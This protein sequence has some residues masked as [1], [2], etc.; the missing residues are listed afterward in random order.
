MVVV[1]SFAVDEPLAE[2]LEAARR[3]PEL[4]FF[5]TGNPELARRGLLA[6]K[7]TNVEFTGFVSEEKYA[8]LLRAADVVV[9]LTTHLRLG[10]ASRNLLSR[11]SP[12][13]KR[14]GL[15][16]PRDRRSTST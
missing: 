4:R 10:I 13:P 12:R 9:V 6:S 7:P 8:G 16:T 15:Y 2:L 3:L 5:V 1:N 11:D 14:A